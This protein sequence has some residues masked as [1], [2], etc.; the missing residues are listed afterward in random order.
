MSP[1]L[2]GG[3]VSSLN[4]GYILASIVMMTIFC[5]IVLASIDWRSK[6]ERIRYAYVESEESRKSVRYCELDM[7][8]SKVK[9]VERVCDIMNLIFLDEVASRWWFEG[10]SVDKKV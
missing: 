7:L 1:L 10:H 2:S 4:L 5:Q 9:I 8:M 6:S 3:L